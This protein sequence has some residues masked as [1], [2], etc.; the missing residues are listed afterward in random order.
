MHFVALCTD[1]P[2]GLEIRMQHRPEHL[3]WLEANKSR[4]LLAG[5]FLSA[6]GQMTGSML[7]VEAADEADAQALLAGDPFAKVGLFSASEV[8]PW[9]RTFGAAI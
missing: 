4:I 2:D 1:K 9:R 5:P 8:K 6:E 7:I 3:G